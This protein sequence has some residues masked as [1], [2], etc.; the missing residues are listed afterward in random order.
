MAMRA[1]SAAVVNHFRPSMTQLSPSSRARV[2]IH[3][4]FE[5]GIAGSVMEK[6]LRMRPAA[7]G[8]SQVRFCSAVPNSWRISMFPTSGAWQWKE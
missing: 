4:G 7:S 3:A 6:Q 5:P 8:S 2:A 1:P